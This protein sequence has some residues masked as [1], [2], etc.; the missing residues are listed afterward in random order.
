MSKQADRNSL[1]F[2]WED[3]TGVIQSGHSSQ[4]E[5][6]VPNEPGPAL[7]KVTVRSDA[8][9]VIKSVHYTILEPSA[10]STMYGNPTPIERPQSGGTPT[11]LSS[12]SATPPE[13]LIL[14]LTA[15]QSAA[16]LGTYII[17]AGGGFS[18]L[19]AA[20]L[21]VRNFRKL[22]YPSEVFSL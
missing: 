11:G 6:V 12:L 10:T 18:S 3:S 7:L 9:E 2:I 5:Y 14:A 1:T 8:N 19:D 22:P 20:W 21:Y 15:T 17:V 4:L 16:S 13:A